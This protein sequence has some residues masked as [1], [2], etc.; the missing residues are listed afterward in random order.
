MSEQRLGPRKIR[1]KVLAP[2]A[3][4]TDFSVGAVRDNPEMNRYV[5]LQ[6]A[7]G[8]AGLPAG[9]DAAT[10]LLPSDSAAWI[11][12]QRIEAFGGMFI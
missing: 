2:G 1:V 12:P 8:R 10:A 5:A 6:T 11:M 7:L 4:E 3:I 9:I